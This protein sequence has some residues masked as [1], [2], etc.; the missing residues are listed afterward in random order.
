MAYIV[1]TLIITSLLT[2]LCSPAQPE[3]EDAIPLYGR[4]TYQLGAIDGLTSD[5]AVDGVL[6]TE[7]DG[8]KYCAHPNNTG[9]EPV[10]WWIDLRQDYHIYSVT[11]HNTGDENGYKAMQNF[12]IR[13]YRHDIET[14]ITCAEYPA[15]VEPAGS[16]IL[17]CADQVYGRYVRFVR[18][19]GEHVYTVTICEVEIAG[20]KYDGSTIDI[21]LSG[22]STWQTGVSD[23]STSDKAVDGKL[24]DQEIGLMACAVPFNQESKPAEWWIDLGQPFKITSVILHN[25][26]DKENYKNMQDFS[27]L[28]YKSRTSSSMECVRHEAQVAMGAQITL[29]CQHQVYGRYVK[30]IR[31]GGPV[32][33]TVALCEV[34]IRGQ[35]YSASI[36]DIPLYGKPTNQTGVFN[37]LTSEKAVDGTLYNDKYQDKYC[38][39][40]YN[41]NGD[42]AEWWIDLGELYTLLT[43]KIYN[44]GTP[45]DF[46]RLENFAIRVYR[47]DSQTYRTC[48]NYTERVGPGENVTITCAN[49]VTGQYVQFIRLGGVDVDRVTLCEIEMI[50][51]HYSGCPAGYYGYSCDKPCGQCANVSDDGLDSPC[52]SSGYCINGCQMWWAGYTCKTKVAKPVYKG[53][54]VLLKSASSDEIELFLQQVDVL[55]TISG[56]YGY[57]VS[58]GADRNQD[59]E[60]GNKERRSTGTSSLKAKHDS[61]KRSIIV[62]LP[63]LRHNT[64][65]SVTVRPY[66]SMR[67][68]YDYGDSYPTKTFKTKCAAPDPPTFTPQIIPPTT[69]AGRFD[70]VITYQVPNNTGCD[71]LTSLQFSFRPD[72]GY[73]DWTTVPAALTLDTLILRSLQQGSYVLKM[74]ATNNKGFISESEYVTTEIGPN[75]IAEAEKASGRLRSVYILAIIL[76]IMLFMAILIAIIVSLYKRKSKKKREA[77]MNEGRSSLM[78]AVEGPKA[79][80]YRVPD[81]R[82]EGK[83]ASTL[84]LPY[85]GR[86]HALVPVGDE[87]SQTSSDQLPTDGSQVN[88]IA[89]WRF[90]DYFNNNLRKLKEEYA[91]LPIVYDYPQLD[92]IKPENIKK[93]LYKDIYPYDKNRVKLFG[94]IGRTYGNY[95]NAS[96]I[97]GYGNKERAYI[98]AQ[99]PTPDTICLF[100]AMIWQFK[101]KKIVMLLNLEEKKPGEK[102]TVPYWSDTMDEEKRYNE[103]AVTMCNK[104]VYAHYTI[105]YLKL[106]AMHQ[107]RVVVHF[108]FTSWRDK[109]TPLCGPPALLRLIKR[110]NDVDGE[111]TKPILVHCRAGVGRTGTYIA[112]DI[113]LKQKEHD[114]CVDIP[115][116][117]NT[118]REQRKI[119]VQTLDQY[120]FIHA[121]L[122]EAILLDNTC[123]SKETLA[124]TF[125]DI[126]ARGAF[127][128]LANQYTVLSKLKL[129]IASHSSR[130]GSS[131]ENTMKNRD[132]HV[133]PDDTFRPFLI[134]PAYKCN[135]YINAVFIDSFTTRERFI[136]T[137][138]P[139]PDTHVDFWRLVYDYRVKCIVMLNELDKSDKTCKQYWVAET[140]KTFGT[141]RVKRISR[142]STDGRQVREFVVDLVQEEGRQSQSKPVEVVHH[143]LVNWP[144]KDFFPQDRKAFVSLLE[145]VQQLLRDPAGLDDGQEKRRIIV[146]C[147]NGVSRSGLFCA[148]SHAIEQVRR[149]GKVDVFLAARYATLRRPQFFQTE[150]EYKLLY[151]IVLEYLKTYP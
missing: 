24:Y 126:C 149:D 103:F 32:I 136:V 16:V 17:H 147:L 145:A 134:T 125:R 130:S 73:T 106:S 10:Y 84:A 20:Q 69:S 53:Q 15:Q 58:Y 101:V 34:V 118:L 78:L 86:R 31:L 52:D 121:A 85:S 3:P 19:G 140:P 122:L 5:K 46:E 89:V 82:N 131:R 91:S 37:G 113:L 57:E 72:D 65:Y 9:G 150:E 41:G 81:D 35:V 18:I 51:Q 105:R 87:G 59:H 55:S 28:V 95:I 151:E 115:G 96:F 12:A 90:E 77:R 142:Q 119:M 112:L 29:P 124:K 83:Q 74:I 128:Q 114:N 66:R 25:A 61:N 99:G 143:Q 8:D 70:I 27:I 43:V 63:G 139:L 6:Y 45:G 135:D 133:I 120:V 71:S 116:C 26:G 40:P 11:L 62:T 79:L 30:F 13:V 97:K 64:P 100:W 88:G 22:K 98:A 14:A 127:S 132:P 36:V 92:A 104:I 107:D 38:A 39:H 48:G 94:D 138:M 102:Q 129:L 44:T 146:H 21:P 23:L 111:D 54:Q 49:H 68:Q 4:R 137:Q 7:N 60:D 67:G 50:G 141:L 33:N 123:Y 2:Q 56:Y 109:T 42:P 75:P 93:N 76:G 110:V 117:V 80:E 108:Q 1:S 148:A 144:N 47:P